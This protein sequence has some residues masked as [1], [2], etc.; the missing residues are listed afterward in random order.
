MIRIMVGVCES[1]VTPFKMREVSDGSLI[2]SESACASV[3]IRL[4]TMKGMKGSNERLKR[5]V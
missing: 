1:S 5:E 3:K 4:A 2:N